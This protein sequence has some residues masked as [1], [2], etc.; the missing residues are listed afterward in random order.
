MEGRFTYTGSTSECRIAVSIDL[1]MRSCIMSERLR[2]LP[3]A[4]FVWLTMAQPI[5]VCYW[6]GRSWSPYSTSP[7]GADPTI[8]EPTARRRNLRHRPSG[9]PDRTGNDVA[10]SPRTMSRHH[11]EDRSYRR[12][13]QLARY[14]GSYDEGGEQCRRRTAGEKCGNKDKERNRNRHAIANLARS[15]YNH[16]TLSGG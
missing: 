13:R 1:L 10:T 8:P 12:L 16:G 11:P 4:P 3:I 9:V 7:K 15:F 14:V 2:R 5:A 6:C